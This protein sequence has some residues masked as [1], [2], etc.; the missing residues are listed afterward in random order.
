M[1]GSMKGEIQR[2]TGNDP[3]LEASAVQ[4]ALSP[5]CGQ[6]F[7]LLVK[8]AFP[9]GILPSVESYQ[10][11]CTVFSAAANPSWRE[12]LPHRNGV[13]SAKGKVRLFRS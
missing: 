10:E 2:R 11:M 1:R 9:I 12:S 6:G 7:V 3:H 5:A 8:G 13:R 4:D